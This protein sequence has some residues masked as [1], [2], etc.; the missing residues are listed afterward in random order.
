LGSWRGEK[1]RAAKGGEKLDFIGGEKTV[2]RFFCRPRRSRSAG[3]FIAIVAGRRPFRLQVRSAARDRPVF[4]A[5]EVWNRD[6]RDLILSGCFLL[7]FYI[8]VIFG[9]MG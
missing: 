1:N 8:E 5:K 9:G 4:A 2:P 7:F 3:T 6:F